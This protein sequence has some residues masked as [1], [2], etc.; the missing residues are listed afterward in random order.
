VLAGDTVYS[1]VDGKPKSTRAL[2]RL[3]NIT[4]NPAVSL[5]VDHY[6]DDWTQLWWVR[7]DGH[8]TVVDVTDPEAVRAL[9]ALSA[10]YPQ[11]AADPP[12]GPMVRV[13]VR[14]WSSWRHGGGG[15]V[16]A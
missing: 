3:A 15:T 11:Y 9:A 7:A 16:S 14:R 2:K 13:D 8:A 4:A 10:K 5:L 12:A 1:A 6:D